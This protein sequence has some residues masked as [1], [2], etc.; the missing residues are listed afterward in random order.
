MFD[1]VVLHPYLTFKAVRS[2][3][4]G[5]QHVNKVSSA[6]ELYFDI[7]NCSALADEQKAMI[8]SKLKHR[9]NAAGVL[10]LVSQAERSQHAN[11]KNV[12]SRFD[13]LITLALKKK[14]KRI[15]TRI[16]EAQKKKRLESKRKQSEKKKLRRLRDED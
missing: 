6:V 11:K 10:M 12:I 2:G 3:G 4:K 7:P 16:S 5:G 15:P 9:I 14:A 13:E 8:L 1:P